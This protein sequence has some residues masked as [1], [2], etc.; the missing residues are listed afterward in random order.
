MSDDAGELGGA[1]T[2]SSKGSPCRYEPQEGNMNKARTLEA[3]SPGLLRVMERARRNPNE[4]QFALAHLIDV[5][6]LRRAYERLR[7]KSAVG[8]DGVTK[9]EYGQELEE[10][11]QNLHGRLKA[12]KYRHQPIRRVHIPKDKDRTRPIGISTIE[13]KIVQGALREILEAIYEQDFLDCSY[14]FRPGRSAHDAMRELNRAV[15]NGEANVILEADIKSFFD[16][17]DRPMMMEMLQKRIADKS[18]MRLVGK[19]LHVGVLD[20]EIFSRPDEGT[21]QGSIVSPILGNIYLHNALDTWFEQEVKPRL[22]GKSVLIRYADDFL[23]GFEH[24]EDAER[25]MD[26]LGKRLERFKLKLHPEK[27][28]LLNFGRPPGG[29]RG[30]KGPDSFDLLGFTMYWRHNRKGPGWHMSMK[31]KRAN[32]S[33]AER[34]INELCR[35][36]RHEPVKVQHAA[37]VRY[38][39]GHFNYFGVNDN[40]RCLS[41][42]Q[43]KAKRT[44]YKWLCRRSQRSRLNWKRFSDLIRDFPLPMPRVY[45]DLWATP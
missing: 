39:H 28:R 10:S 37:L 32:L 4:R 33:R 18:L 2:R 42:L 41:S 44:W 20:G 23:I 27:T 31:T 14:G 34:R 45:K 36:Q 6:A 9:E 16:T 7:K 1:W 24:G 19:C 30:G 12:M 26:V 29:R 15:R 25:V 17:I 35:R 11:L 40:T 13:D 3:M 22:R 8:V 5:G 43:E 38:L 21:V